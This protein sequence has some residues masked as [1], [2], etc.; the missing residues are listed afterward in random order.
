MV[1]WFIGREAIQVLKDSK[2]AKPGVQRKT[3][4]DQLKSNQ[5]KFQNM[6]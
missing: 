4:K 5:V 3:V 2:K 1:D 6:I